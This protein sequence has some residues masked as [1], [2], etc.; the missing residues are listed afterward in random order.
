MLRQ[1]LSGKPSFYDKIQ[2]LTGVSPGSKQLYKIAFRHSSISTKEYESNERLEFLGD[3]ILSAIIANYLFKKFPFKDEGY[4]TELRSKMVSRAQL[5]L[6]AQKM[7]IDELIQ[8]NTAD[9]SISK[10]TLGGNALEALVGAVYLDKGF[11]RTS[12][13]ILKKIVH[14]Y[15]D[16]E[17]L[18]I[19]EFNYKSKLLEWAQRYGKRLSYAVKGESRQ[20]NRSWY[21]VA[22][23]IDGIEYGEGVDSNKKNAEKNAARMAFEKLNISI[24]EFL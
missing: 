19:A 14:P 18:E 4:L 15:L 13:F 21:K 3:A 17:E 24:E 8:F 16:V 20:H 10:K 2:Q 1:L 5:N 11:K 12:N 23:I 6:I 22:A 9:S 7:G